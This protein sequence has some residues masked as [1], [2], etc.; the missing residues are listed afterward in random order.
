MNEAER[1]AHFSFVAVAK[2]CLDKRKCEN[3]FDL[4]NEMLNGYKFLGFNTSIKV[5]YL[6]SHLDHFRENLEDTS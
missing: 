6:H 1:K 4:V 2:S 5:H 3:Y